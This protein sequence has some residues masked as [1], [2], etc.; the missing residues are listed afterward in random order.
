MSSLRFWTSFFLSLKLLGNPYKVCLARTEVSNSTQ[1]NTQIVK[2]YVR[3]LNK[4]GC[5]SLDKCKRIKVA[6]LGCMYTVA[7]RCIPILAYM[8]KVRQYMVNLE[9]DKIAAA[10]ATFKN[11][12]ITDWKIPHED[13]DVNACKVPHAFN[14]NIAADLV[15]R[16]TLYWFGELEREH[17][18]RL[19]DEEA[20]SEHRALPTVHMKALVI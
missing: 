16:E 19:R 3:L 9:D 17:G 11:K 5:D 8:E 18:M 2:D 14:V 6:A 10:A 15:R 13:F 20:Q 1:L 12:K 4:D 7:M